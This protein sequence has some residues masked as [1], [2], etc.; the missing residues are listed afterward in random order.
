MERQEFTLSTANQR[1]LFERS[2]WGRPTATPSVGIAT[3]GGAALSAAADTNVTLDTVDTTLT[4]S[5]AEGAT[6]I[7]L[8]AVTGVAVGTTYW[9]TN[10]YGQETQAQVLKI[11]TANKTVYLTSPLKVAFD[12]LS[13]ASY[14]TFEGVEFYYTLQSAD[15][16]TLREMNIGKATFTAGGLPRVLRS[17]F[18]IVNVPLNAPGPLTAEAVYE[19]LG[20]D[21]VKQEP[22]EQKGSD[23]APQRYAAWNVVR[24]A[25]YQ[26]GDSQEQWRPSMIVDP[27]D[28]FEYGIAAFTTICHQ[29]AI[30][31]IRIKPMPTNEELERKEEVQRKLAMNTV[32]WLDSDESETKSDTETR[33]L[34]QDLVR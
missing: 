1:L 11:D 5:A 26:H 27:S 22:P 31:V 21:L 29:Q 8:A 14:G 30:D 28:L 3:S 2:P 24:R 34:T 16:S 23:F 17:T 33:P 10:I 7:V 13:G 4:A 6:S 19:R 25:I 12:L 18:D 15:Y 9:L 32:S 20:R